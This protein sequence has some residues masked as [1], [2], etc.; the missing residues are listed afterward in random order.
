M[1]T[2]YNFGDDDLNNRQDRNND[3]RS[4]SKGKAGN[5]EDP[6]IEGNKDELVATVVRNVRRGQGLPPFIELFVNFLRLAAENDLGYPAAAKTLR[7]FEDFST[8]G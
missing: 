5:P 7:V 4:R 2:N 3:D 8:L 6:P 1:G